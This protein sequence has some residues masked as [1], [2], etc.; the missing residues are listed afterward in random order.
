MALGGTQARDVAHPFSRLL[1]GGPTSAPGT[2]WNCSRPSNS[3][4]VCQWSTPCTC[5]RWP[6]HCHC[7]SKAHDV[8]TETVAIVAPGG[9]VIVTDSKAQDSE[10][11]AQLQ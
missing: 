6:D 8:K 10:D 3:S 11:R 2:P 9:L 1:H 4:S 5:T 7:D